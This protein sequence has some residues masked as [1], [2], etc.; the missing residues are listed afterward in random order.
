MLVARMWRYIGARRWRGPG[1]GPQG[2]S[3]RRG[4]KG[5]A[6][7][8]ARHRGRAWARQEAGRWAKLRAGLRP[9]PSPG[10][11]LAKPLLQRLPRQLLGASGARLLQ[12]LV[13]KLMRLAGKAGAKSRHRQPQKKL[14]AAPQQSCAPFLSQP[15]QACPCCAASAALAGQLAGSAAGCS[16]GAAEEWASSAGFARAASGCKLA[17]LSP[18]RLPLRLGLLRPLLARR[19]LAA[20]GGSWLSFFPPP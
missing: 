2:Q 16:K 18:Y 10:Q 11:A 3:S 4:A 20:S 7:E 12:L 13:P 1:L 6:Q 15:W 5:S 14:P 9:K 8:Q 17:G 19:Q